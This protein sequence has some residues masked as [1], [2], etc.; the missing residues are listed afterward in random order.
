MLVQR[1]IDRDG[2]I[3]ILGPY[4]SP[5]TDAEA[6]VVERAQVPM[7]G[8][9][10]SDSSIWTRRKLHWSFQ[11]FPSSDYDH[12]GFIEILNDKGKGDVKKVAVIFEEAPFS[13]ASKDWAMPPLK[14]L[15]FDGRGLRLS[16]GRPG[17]PLDH[18]AHAQF[19][20][21]RRCRWA[22]TTSRA[23]R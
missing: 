15:G 8:T 7:L 6:V 2:S 16:P 20:R 18:R 22:A 11:A 1:L 14:E 12:Q 3:A 21:R 9:I 4:S 17:F 23:S 10:A 13:I 5:I 19:R